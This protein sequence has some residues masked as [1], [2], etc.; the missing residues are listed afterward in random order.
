LNSPIK[1]LQLLNYVLE[2]SK[3]NSGY[4]PSL[5]N[6]CLLVKRSQAIGIGRVP[7]CFCLQFGMFGY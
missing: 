1:R 5:L 2:K 3:I 7:N 6:Y 4:L